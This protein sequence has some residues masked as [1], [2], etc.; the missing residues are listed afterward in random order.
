MFDLAKFRQ[1]E[2]SRREANLDKAHRQR[3]HESD[4]T[5]G[6]LHIVY[7]LTH[8]GVC[9]GTKIILEHA[10]HLVA[11]GQNVTLVSHFEKPDWFP[12]DGRVGYIRVPFEEELTF[13]IPACDVIVATYWREIF[14]CILRNIAPVVYFEQG[15]YH[16]FDYEHVSERER[17]Y[18]QTQYRT[19]PFIFTVSPG[20]A[21]TIRHIYHR[22]ATVIPNAIDH[23]IF[24]PG[25]K[26]PAP[27]DVLRIAMIGSESNDF[28]RT[29]DILK[30][31]GDLQSRGHAV[32]LY[33]VSPDMPQNPQG[34]LAVNPTQSIIGDFLRSADYLISASTY[35]SFSLPPLEAMACG[36]AV[37]TTKNKGVLSYAREG[38]NCVFVPM[39]NPCA[40][41]HAIEALHADKA[42][43][44]NI[45]H[46]GYETAKRFS[47]ETVTPQLIAYYRE[48]ARFR[49]VP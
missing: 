37:V 27:P 46:G 23:R 21:A 17:N 12:I 10:S 20:A 31:L 33:W 24:H 38:E 22:N 19:V 9:G 45:M 43:R 4:A 13:G 28:K 47:W 11:H 39:Q 2:F 26:E 42:L 1:E 16:L 18:I 30:A 5:L 35:E 36:C 8:T 34:R 15:D 41:A 49:P 3:L 14:E 6:A 32:E 29:S 44:E 48:V 40:I 25:Q 7:V